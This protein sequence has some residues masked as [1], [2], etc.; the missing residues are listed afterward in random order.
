M[1]LPRYR[2]VL[3]L[4]MFL[5]MIVFATMEYMAPTP[6]AKIIEEEL[7]I[8]EW[9]MGL[10]VGIVGLIL[11]LFQF[12]TGLVVDRLGAKNTITLS[13]TL[14]GVGGC[15]SAFSP[16]FYTLLLSR[17]IFAIGNVLHMP[18]ISPIIMTWFSVDEYGKAQTVPSVSPSLGITLTMAFVPSY[19]ITM[20]WRNV[21]LLFAIILLILDIIWFFAGR[22]P[23]FKREPSK[24]PSLTKLKKIIKVRN[25]LLCGLAMFAVPGFIIGYFSWFTVYAEDVGYPFHFLP[26]ALF[27]MGSIIGIILGGTLMDRVGLRRP[28]MIWAGCF[29]PILMVLLVQFVTWGTPLSIVLP[30]AFIGSML[31]MLVGPAPYVIPMESEGVDPEDIHWAMALNLFL[32]FTGSFIAPILIGALADITGTYYHGLMIAAVIP[33]LILISGMLMKETGWKAVAS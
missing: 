26:M 14:M 24:L 28:F 33:I 12:F 23:L 22:D 16:D 1:R 3:L 31:F 20:G 8:A 11:A 10:I 27:S 30:L 6:I 4:G 15:L 29:G 9:Q 19:L 5:P 21:L 2:W 18:A 17:L 13:L 32:A 7:G 25:V